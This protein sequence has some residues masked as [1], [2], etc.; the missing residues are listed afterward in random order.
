MEY[1][2]WV[3]RIFLVI[4]LVIQQI[5]IHVLQFQ[6][7]ENWRLLI[8]VDQRNQELQVRLKI[9]ENHFE[10]FT[11]NADNIEEVE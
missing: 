5:S 8:K 10:A 6:E 4:I 3:C 11:N 9:L 1:I 7:L 2:K